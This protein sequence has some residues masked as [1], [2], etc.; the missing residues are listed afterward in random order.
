MSNNTNIQKYN[1]LFCPFCKN[2]FNSFLEVR[3]VKYKVLGIDDKNKIFKLQ[4]YDNDFIYK[5]FNSYI[6]WENYPPNCVIHDKYGN[7]KMCPRF[8]YNF[9][10]NYD[11][12]FVIKN[13]VFNEDDNTDKMEF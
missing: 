11:K 10:T 12:Q 6:L 7:D 1:V 9:Q 5:Y 4:E 8:C 2:P 3:K 13:I